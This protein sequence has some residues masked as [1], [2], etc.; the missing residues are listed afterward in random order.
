MERVLEIYERALAG[1]ATEEEMN[2][3]R[4]WLA[5]RENTVP[6]QELLEQSFFRTTT[7]ADIPAEKA[8]AILQAIVAV[9]KAPA[10][11]PRVFTLRRW[12][13]AA[14]V[15]LLLAAGTAYYLLQQ[16]QTIHTPTMADVAPAH[17][18]AILTLSD[19]SQVVLDSAKNGLVA[20]QNG[21]RVLL[22]SGQLSY[23]PVAGSANEVTYNTINTP[24]GRQFNLQLPDGTMVWLNAASSIRYPTLFNGTERKVEITG[25]AYFEVAQNSK[26]P[27]RISA[28]NQAQVEVL[29]T[30]FNINA[31]GDNGTINTTLISGAVA[32]KHTSIK[33][34]AAS[35]RVILKPGQAAQIKIAH[36]IDAADKIKVI[37]DADINKAVAWKNG[38]FNLEGASLKEVMKEIERWYDIE[39]V[40]EN[41][42]IPDIYFTGEMSRNVTLSSFLKALKE[43]QINYRLE[44]KR[45]IILP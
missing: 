42:K 40:Y 41:D 18:G 16:H 15:T 5:D 35:G 31:Y 7:T 28:G 24:K 21:A 19:G 6:A 14:S 33:G 34:T 23:N 10:V 39:V 25:E 30:S 3:L 11:I 12:W 13:A 20:S 22:D 2:I 43:W 37:P 29:G 36:D 9:D 44:N 32:V 27:F 26:M 8:Q 4:S 45:L 1:K 38:A 17:K